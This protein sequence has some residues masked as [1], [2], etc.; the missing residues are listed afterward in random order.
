MGLEVTSELLKQVAVFKES[1]TFANLKKQLAASQLK[2]LILPISAQLEAGW[3]K[4]M[5]FSGARAQEL[6]PFLL[7]HYNNANASDRRAALVDG[8][9]PVDFA[10][11]F[12]DEE[13]DVLFGSVGT[14][15]DEGSDNLALRSKPGSAATLWQ[16]PDG[17]VVTLETLSPLGSHDQ[18]FDPGYDPFALKEGLRR[19]LNDFLS[20]FGVDADVPLGILFSDTAFAEGVRD[21]S[22]LD[23]ARRGPEKRRAQNIVEG[24]MVEVRSCASGLVR[25]LADLPE[26]ETDSSELY[27]WPDSNE[28][29][30][31][32]NHLSVAPK[33]EMDKF[34]ELKERLVDAPDSLEPDEVGVFFE[35]LNKY[36][37]ATPCNALPGTFDW[38]EAAQESGAARQWIAAD[39]VNRPVQPGAQIAVREDCKVVLLNMEAMSVC[40]DYVG[41]GGS[42]LIV[43]TIPFIAY[44]SRVAESC[45]ILND[46]LEGDLAKQLQTDNFTGTLRDASAHSDSGPASP[47]LM[48]SPDTTDL[49]ATSVHFNAIRGEVIAARAL[50]L[51]A[52]YDAQFTLSENFHEWTQGGQLR[53]LLVELG[54]K[55]AS[56]ISTATIR[57]AELIQKEIEVSL[58]RHL[59]QQT[60]VLERSAERERREEENRRKQVES[61]LIFQLI[62]ALVVGFVALSLVV[63]T[64]ATVASAPA[65]DGQGSLGLGIGVISTVLSMVVGAAIGWFVHRKGLI[66][67]R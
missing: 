34:L 44:R 30:T 54:K 40:H 56:V 55:R 24:L 60:L 64:M 20:D 41:V 27:N 62:S 50:D 51:K 65:V 53:T 37:S 23:V 8:L 58:E 10:V 45:R 46:Y 2:V 25:D 13:D 22:L 28:S 5:A 4:P 38:T 14:M 19:T 12:A 59:A 52:S 18:S 35:D 16:T 47:S 11:V 36:Q 21:S 32:T 63:T 1:A 15:L 3:S 7:C 61:S 49:D 42:D 43:A 33:L 57:A 31:W 29:V 67:K 48:I 9:R 26:P 6:N 66:P 39:V 17:L